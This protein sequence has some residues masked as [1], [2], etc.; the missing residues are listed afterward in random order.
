MRVKLLDQP[1]VHRHHLKTNKAG[2]FNHHGHLYP[3]LDLE[4]LTGDKAFLAA[5][6]LVLDGYSDC[7]FKS[8]QVDSFSPMKLTS[9]TPA[10]LR[11]D[12]NRI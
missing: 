3:R 12:E 11:L 4:N 9:E 1:E 5:Q 7:S 6:Q 2:S 10:D 8:I